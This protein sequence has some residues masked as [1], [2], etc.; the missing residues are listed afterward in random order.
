MVITMQKRFQFFIALFIVVLTACTVGKNY[1]R[2]E[3]E[4][5][6]QFGNTAPSDTS[7]AGMEWKKFFTDT[8]LQRLIEHALA[9]NFDLQIAMKRINEAQAYVK[10]AKMN[11]APEVE[12][13]AS[14][15]TSSP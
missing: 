1:Q 9:G 2:P 13:Q 15:S 11:Y 4:L 3:L 7:I 6:Q 5:P 12:T 10:Q 14:A 8:T